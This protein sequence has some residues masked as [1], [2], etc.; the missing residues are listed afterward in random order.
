MYRQMELGLGLVPVLE[1]TARRLDVVDFNVFAA[2]LAMHRPTGGNLPT[3]LDRLA[4]ATRE[5]IQ[6]EGQYRAATAMGRVSAG[7][8]LFMVGVIMLY[9]FFVDREVALHFFETST[10]IMLFAMAMVLEVFGGVMLFFLLRF[11][12]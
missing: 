2:V 7:F 3:I 10:G 1:T 6:F 5:R 8:I 11:D 9:F 4:A 12:V